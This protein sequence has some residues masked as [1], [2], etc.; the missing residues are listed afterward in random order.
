MGI[1]AII[2]LFDFDVPNRDISVFLCFLKNEIVINAP[3]IT[4]LPSRRKVVNI[5]IQVGNFFFHYSL[6]LNSMTT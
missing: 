4:P 5:K 1:T 6:P 3:I 2:R